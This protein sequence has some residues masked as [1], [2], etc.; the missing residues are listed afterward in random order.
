MVKISKFTIFTLIF[1][2]FL[3]LTAPIALKYVFAAGQGKIGIGTIWLKVPR[4]Y[5]NGLDVRL[6]ISGIDNNGAAFEYIRNYSQSGG[7]GALGILDPCIDHLELPN[8]PDINGVS[9]TLTAREKYKIE[10]LSINH[11]LPNGQIDLSGTIACN[12]N[13]G[14]WSKGVTEETGDII[15]SW[16]PPP[17]TPPILFLLDIQ[18]TNA[19]SINAAVENIDPRSKY[20]V[21]INKLGPGNRSIFNK[22]SVFTVN[23]SQNNCSFEKNELSVDCSAAATNPS[24]FSVLNASFLING[25]MFPTVSSDETYNITVY[26]WDKNNSSPTLV[27]VVSK[28]IVLRTAL[29][30]NDLGVT[31]APDTI[32]AN[33][34]QRIIINVSKATAGNKYDATITTSSVPLS[35]KDTVATGDT[36]EIVFNTKDSSGR[37][38]FTGDGP[39]IVTV[40]EQGTRKQ[41]QAQLTVGNGARGGTGTPLTP[42]IIPTVPVGDACDYKNTIKTGSANSPGTATAI[43]CIPTDPIEFIGS[44]LRFVI[45]IIGGISL[46]IMVMAVFQMITSAGN[47]DNLKQGHERFTSAIIGM[48][49]VIFSVL[50][51]RIIGVDILGLG[52]ALGV[53]F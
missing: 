24:T 13:C 51:L 20:M 32:T 27:P 7:C 44:L 53:G 17:A 28:S 39:Q 15:F 4:G 21:K 23:S 11:F 2:T 37:F 26:Q 46:L 8:G 33:T 5:D 19:D 12:N 6:K 34:D 29:L 50:L 36:V 18:L 14:P 47:P 49:V 48:L 52:P 10:I 38:L 43:G 30:S 1:L 40:S 42:T 35:I 31:L 22:E 3:F 45:G 25:S 9:P 41:G 16:S